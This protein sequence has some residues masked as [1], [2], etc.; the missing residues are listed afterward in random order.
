MLIAAIQR[1]GRCHHR[2]LPSKM[3]QRNAL[4]LLGRYDGQIEGDPVA[5]ARS[6]C[7][8]CIS[9]SR[10]ASHSP[11]NVGCA[12]F[13]FRLDGSQEPESVDGSLG[14][15]S[16]LPLI[17]ATCVGTGLLLLIGWLTL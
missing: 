17:I 5:C 8:R 15:R 3:G 12:S 11:T 16:D 7:A 14:N 1:Q 4:V 2:P 6:R 9:T 13:P 10:T